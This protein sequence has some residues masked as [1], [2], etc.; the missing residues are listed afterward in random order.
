MLFSK[1]TAP[2]PTPPAMC[3]CSNASTPSTTL[4][5]VCLSDCSHPRVGDRHMA[6]HPVILVAFSGFA[7][8]SSLAPRGAGERPSQVGEDTQFWG[9]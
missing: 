1:V 2:F 4:V 3:K 7:Q 8:D 5:I 9:L 6:S